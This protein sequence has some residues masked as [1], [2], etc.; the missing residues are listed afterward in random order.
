MEVGVG[1]VVVAVDDD[2]L[3][4][5]VWPIEVWPILVGDGLGRWVSRWVSRWMG[6]WVGR[7]GV[8]AIEGVGVNVCGRVAVVLHEP[9]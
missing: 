6:R 1:A 3:G 9:N 8:G 4:A 2:G 5:V 7:V